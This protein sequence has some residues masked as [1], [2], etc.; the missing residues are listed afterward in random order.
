LLPGCAQDAPVGGSLCR[1]FALVVLAGSQGLRVYP[2]CIQSVSRL[3]P[4]AP[5]RLQRHQRIHCVPRVYPVCIHRASDAC[6]TR[7]PVIYTTCIQR[8]SMLYPWCILDAPMV[9]LAPS[10]VSRGVNNS[11]HLYPQRIRDVSNVYTVLVQRNA[12]PGVRVMP[13]TFP[14][15][16][17]MPAACTQLVSNMYP[18]CIQLSPCR[19]RRPRCIPCVSNVYP[20]RIQYVPYARASGA[21]VMH[22][23]CIHR[24]SV[25]NPVCIQYAPMVPP[26]RPKVSRGVSDAHPVYPGRIQ[27]VSNVYLRLGQIGAFPGV[28]AWRA[29]RV[30]I[31]YPSCIHFVSRHTSPS[32]SRVCPI[33]AQ[34]VLKSALRAPWA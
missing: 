15:V 28:C 11:R 2:S 3:Y 20:L 10:Q 13:A 6:A 12:F 32:V 8:V 5:C 1:P 14:G 34:V 31:V 30:Y 24:V 16:C 21:P 9:S 25:V 19:R 4:G 22:T 29:H 27:C 17:V 23:Q 18:Y 26:A 7:A 33:S